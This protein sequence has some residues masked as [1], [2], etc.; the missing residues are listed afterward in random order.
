MFNKVFLIA[1]LIFSSLHAK[2]SFTSERLLGIEVGYGTLKTTD[3]AGVESSSK[4]AEYGFRIGAQNT[5][6]RTTLATNFYR[7]GDKKYQRAMLEFDRFVWA[8][9]Y[10][11]DSIVFK[12]YLGGH[13]GWMRYTDDAVGTKDNGFLYG[14]KVGLAWNVLREVDFDLGYRYSVTNISTVNN[15]GG[16]VFGVN[17]IY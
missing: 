5:D 15:L 7:A 14:G 12:P 16:F 3:T 17:Y 8:S 10:K 9:L 4:D 2:D 11:T 6:W 1:F 13:I